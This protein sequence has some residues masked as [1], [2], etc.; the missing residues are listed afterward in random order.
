MDR[1]LRRLG[2]SGAALSGLLLLAYCGGSDLTLPSQT[3]PVDIV[4]VDGDN[5]IGSA[6]TPLAKPL[7]VRLIDRR[8]EPVPD[9]SVA[10]IL[11]PQAPGAAVDPDEERTN[12]EGKAQAHWVVGTTSGSQS[13][14]ARVVGA[15]GLEA[16]FDAS[17][18]AG[19]PSGIEA[20]SGDDQT[21]A[22]G[23]SLPNPLV[24]RVTDGFGNPVPDV[25]VEWDAEEGS[26]DPSS[27]RTG[28]D[29][30]ASTAWV[31]GSSTGAQ[32]ATATR[33]GLDGSPVT[34]SSTAIPGTADR[35]VRVSG[36]NQSGRTGEELDE[37]LVVRLVDGEGNGIPGRAVSW[38]IG[39]GGGN[40][41]ST[42]GTTDGNG[43]AGTP[44]TM[45]PTPGTNTL[46]A[47]VSGVGVVEFSATAASGGGGGGGS[48]PSR[49][50]FRVQPSDTEEDTR[51]SPPVEVVVL[52]QDGNRVTDEEIEIKLEVTGDGRGKL[53]GDRNQQT[54]SGVA[55]FDDLEVDRDGD[56]RLRASTD[57]L[58]PV[59]SDRFEVHERRHDDDDD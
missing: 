49:L 22:V 32:T 44:W 19:D 57:G 34:F 36:N 16:R 21:G 11:D 55:T 27:S 24:V 47:V 14:I 17:V 4:K 26:V 6:G 25:L 18:A 42:T 1:L 39:A 30:R 33:E 29:G 54:Q 50:E 3:G 53:K 38:V 52:D 23:T 28:A 15:N 10:F 59:D 41:P 37:L 5:Q 40:V 20:V 8:G 45:G 13:L 46:N 7:V 12:S 48:T 56:Y 9:Q 35:L 43:E 51:I 2:T 58:P 31:L